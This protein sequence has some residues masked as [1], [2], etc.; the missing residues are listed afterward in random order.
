MKKKKKHQIEG[1]IY[2][3]R[4]SGAKFEDK[5]KRKKE[6]KKVIWCQT[7]KNYSTHATQG[8]RSCR[9]ESENINEGYFWVS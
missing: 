7:R 1:L 4:R 6:K 8:G 9:G 3:F 2:K 5:D